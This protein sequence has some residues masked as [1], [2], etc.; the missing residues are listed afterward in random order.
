MTALSALSEH[1]LVVLGLRADF[2]AHALGY[3]GLARALQERQ[4]VVGPMSAD[5]LRRA[6]VEP[7]RK[8]GRDV[9]DGLVE[10]LLADMRPPGVPGPGGHEAGALP[11]LSHA[12]LATWEHGRGSRLTLADYQASGGIRDAIARTAEEAYATL[13]TGEQEIARQLFLRLVHVGNDGR[14]AR[15][16][17]PLRDLPGDASVA[18]AVLERFVGQRLV[19]KDRAAAEIAHEALLGAWPRLRGWIDADREDIRL[20]RFI[21]VAAQTWAQADREAAALL[22]GGQL[23][24]AVDWIAGEAH[25]AALSQDARDFVDAGIAE[26][27]AQQAAARRR[28]RRLRQLVA[29]LTVLVLLTVGLAGYAFH[30]RQ[31][32]TTARDQAESRTVAVEAGQIR[33]EDPALAA[34]LSLAA[35]HISPTTGALAS[36]LESS[37]TPAAARMFD[38][39]RDVQ[40]VALSPDHRLLAVAAADGTLRLWDVHRPGHPAMIGTVP[41]LG[42]THPLYAAAFSP[43]GQVLAAAGEDGMVRLWNVTEP[44]HPMLLD[45]F[46]GPRNTIYS[47]AFS[48]VGGLLAAGSADT[49]V[50]LWNVTDPAHPVQASGP[51]T[52]ASGY[53]QAV[54]FSPDGRLLAAASAD[55]TVRLWTWPTRPSHGSPPR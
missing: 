14:E 27:R 42:R 24:L 11:L 36:L 7:A 39:D 10:V 37:G 52:G 40:A 18:S 5:Q 13:D 19:T 22:R 20:R 30:Q 38:S 23:A 28:T 2:Y 33:P 34:Q 51:L 17:L 53:V 48:P 46:A 21:E 1:T 47:L 6:I 49:T 16:R 43:N 41:A 35:Y 26:E 31:L 15:V 8:A 32:A 4:I 9:E 50:W 3:P 55:T 29:A 12:L 45:R 44:R 25:R 54:A